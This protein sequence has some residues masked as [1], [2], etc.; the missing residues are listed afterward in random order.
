MTQETTERY[1]AAPIIKYHVV[2]RQIKSPYLFESGYK[3]EISWP[4]SSDYKYTSTRWGAHIAARRMIKNYK[5]GLPKIVE[6]YD[7]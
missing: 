3:V 2:I 6:E 4:G 1:T 7:V 5:S